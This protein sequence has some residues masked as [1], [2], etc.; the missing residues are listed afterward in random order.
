MIGIKNILNKNYVLKTT[1]GTLKKE[2]HSNISDYLK[3]HEYNSI[4]E[5]FSQKFLDNIDKENY[6]VFNKKIK[7]FKIKSKKKKDQSDECCAYYICNNNNIIIYR[8]KNDS[9]DSI[10]ERLMHELLHAASS[11]GN[12]LYGGLSFASKKERG[13]LKYAEALNEGYTEYLNQEYF[14]RNT[15]ADYYYGPKVL[16]A[17]IERLVGK[18]EMEKIYFT[19]TLLDLIEAMG[20]YCSKEEALNLIY[21]IEEYNLEKDSK[22]RNEKYIKVRLQIAKLNKIKLDREFQNGKI[23]YETYEKEKLFNVD[24]YQKN[25]IYAEEA[26]IIEEDDDYII[27]GKFGILHEP[28]DQLKLNFEPDLKQTKSYEK[29]KTC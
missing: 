10:R 18:K 9:N 11:K 5:E 2:N 12:G 7:S 21:N 13:Y 25:F 28:K 14:S 4:V 27:Y 29:V 23:D 17:G 26:G 24:L 3:F 1:I 16:A 22:I 19:G 20:V 6:E 15:S 8:T